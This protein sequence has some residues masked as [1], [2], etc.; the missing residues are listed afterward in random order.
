MTFEELRSITDE[1]ERISKTYEIFNED[2]RLNVSN[3][4]SVEFLTNVRYIEKYLN[5]GA[6]ILDVGA[7]T[8]AYSFYFADKGYSVSALE[9]SENN[10]RI[11]KEKLSSRTDID[12][13]QGNAISL[14]AYPDDEFDAVLVFGPLYHLSGEEDKRKCI[15]E[16]KRVC[17]KDGKIFFAF[18]NNDMVFMTELQYDSDYFM[19]GDFEH[20]SFKLHNFPFVFHTPSDCRKMLRDAG[21]KIIHEVASDGFSELLSEKI[22]GMD[23]ANFSEYLRYHFYICEKPEF[24]GASNHLLY[25]CGK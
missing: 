13:R 4:S 15:S 7:G 2:K 16:A 11:F 12:L 19:T 24:I 20:E 14:D 6:K 23:G 5:P 17:K 25:V 8:G 18:I 1:V 10:V 22:N 3:A 21:V 9:L